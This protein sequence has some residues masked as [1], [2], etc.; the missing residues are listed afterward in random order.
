MK[1][2][3]ASP[4]AAADIPQPDA[5][6]VEEDVRRALAED[7]GTGDVTA[8]LIAE[9][10]RARG[11]VLCR[12]AA[13]LC[14]VPWFEAVYAQLDA[15]VA[16]AWS[17][18]DGEAL[19]P[20]DPVCVVEGPARSLLTG[21]RSALNFLQLLSGTATFA[22]RCASA[23]AGTRTKIL[24]TRKTLPGLR[25]AQKYA[26]RCGGCDNHR[27]G[28]FDAIL[29]KENHIAAAGSIEAAV[30]AGRETQPGLVLEVEV[31]TLE[32]L[33]EALSAGAD[34][35]MLDNFAPADIGKAVSRAAGRAK[36]EVSGNVTLEEIRVL[37]AYGVDFVSL[38]AL[39]KDVHAIDFSM[40]FEPAL[41]G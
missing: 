2:V 4:G 12:E 8:A 1:S 35:V 9:T 10:T 3:S 14:G 40:R 23:V 29:I 21:E 34:I 27:M 19:S 39:T 26:V 24:D 32:Q 25:V 41:A 6:Q 18:R 31:E 30:R 36:L 17:S 16:V 15:R 7:V 22:G 11:T 38:G 13:V 33:D 37:A 5:G 28:L 20:D